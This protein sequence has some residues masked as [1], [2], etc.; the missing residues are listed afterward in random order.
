MSSR[1]PRQLAEQA[2]TGPA[3]IIIGGIADGMQSVWFPVVVVCAGTI[4][5]FGF[6]CGWNFE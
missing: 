4:T 1:P 5:A 2:Q 3:T 6:A